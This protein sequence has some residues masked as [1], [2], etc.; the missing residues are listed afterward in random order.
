MDR[1]LR[2]WPVSEYC[3]SEVSLGWVLWSGPDQ[4]TLAGYRVPPPL[5]IDG[6]PSRL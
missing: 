3:E 6:V 1:L 4:E 5:E 2:P